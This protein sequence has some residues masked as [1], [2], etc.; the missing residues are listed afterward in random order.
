MIDTLEVMPRASGK[1]HRAA[2]RA[3][4]ELATGKHVYYLV[5]TY[6]NSTQVQHL[7]QKY[8]S[9]TMSSLNWQ[10]RLAITTYRNFDRTPHMSRRV[11]T[12]PESTF[13]ICDD[14]D[15]CTDPSS[16]PIDAQ[17]YYTT[18]QRQLRT[19]A[20][21]AKEARGELCDPLIHLLKLN[22]WQ[23]TMNVVYPFATTLTHD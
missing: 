7:V 1:T 10:P 6:N 8:A 17:H 5:S 23:C 3:I 13:V 15:W 16:V 11:F 14:F 12:E 4:Q 20:D 19:L 9:S 22:Q 18:T 21:I 2:R